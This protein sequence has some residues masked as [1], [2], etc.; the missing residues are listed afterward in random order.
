MSPQITVRLL[1]IVFLFL[2]VQ[3]LP[4]VTA[5]ANPGA[6][7]SKIQNDHEP[8]TSKKRIA[9]GK[10]RKKTK[11]RFEWVDNCPP[12]PECLEPVAICEDVPVYDCK[13]D[14]A[15]IVAPFEEWVAPIPPPLLEC[16]DAPVI[17]VDPK[18][19]P[20]FVPPLEV[21]G[22]CP[23]CPPPPVCEC[24]ATTCPAPPACPEPLACPPLPPPIICSPPTVCPPLPPPPPPPPTDYAA[25]AAELLRVGDGIPKSWLSKFDCRH[26]LTLVARAS[27]RADFRT[28]ALM[29]AER[30]ARACAP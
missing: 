10:K 4:A 5:Q 23:S 26:L 27:A 6:V 16:P 25:L 30:R 22:T 17:M 28:A 12:C 3:G 11:S 15:P 20:C 8:S 29:S 18:P 14:D 21:C 1:L 24:P 9:H 7:A 13:E 2:A 19:R